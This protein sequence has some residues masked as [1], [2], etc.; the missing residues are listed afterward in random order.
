[1][2]HTW[3]DS[4]LQAAQRTVS[5]LLTL[6]KEEVLFGGDVHAQV[7]AAGALINVIGPELERSD[8]SKKSNLDALRRASGR[9][10]PLRRTSDAGFYPTAS[11][12]TPNR[13]DRQGFSR[14]LKCC[15]TIAMLRSA[16][17]DIEGTQVTSLV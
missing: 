10:R 1:M 5:E 7:C 13:A 6:V 2:L 17:F 15:L 16:I 8:E 9:R 3:S 14:L 4:A 11:P 12:K